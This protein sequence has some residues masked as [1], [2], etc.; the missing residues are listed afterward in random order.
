MLNGIIAMR[1]IFPVILPV[2]VILISIT[3]CGKQKVDPGLVSVSILPQKYFVERIAGNNFRVNVVIPPGHSPATYDPASKQIRETAGSAIY[4]R[5]G[6]IPFEMAHIKRIRELNNEMKVIDTS[7]GIALIK[8]G[9]RHD[10]EG[11]HEH[12]G[13]DP[14]IWLSPAAV[15]IM[16]RNILNAFLE[17]DQ[18]NSRFYKKNYDI[19]LKDIDSL[20]RSIRQLLKKKKGKKFIA[21]HPAWT[22]FARDYGLIQIPIEI[23][24]KEPGPS[25]MKKIIDTARK[26]N[27]RIIFVQKQFP[28]ANAGVI[29][30][31]IDGS[32]VHLDPLA[33]SW[34]SNM[35]KIAEAFNK[36]VNR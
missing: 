1:S 25:H 18:K 21:F 16:C 26:E 36:G 19:L 3:G 10:E 28:T 12:P 15:K 22:Y 31:D 29:A 17:I 6:Y 14:H 27:I 13:I 35:E 30:K 33:L 5:I 34:F 32:V 11:H 23:E 7:R 9:S 8:G 20:D 24:G 2:A 4:F